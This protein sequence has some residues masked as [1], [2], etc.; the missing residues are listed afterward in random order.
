MI[1]TFFKRLFGGG[2][3]KPKQAEPKPPVLYEG[4]EIIAEP[5][6]TN[7]QWQVAGRIEKEIG[8]TRKVHIF[9][10]ADTLPDEEEAVT[11]TLRKAK[12]LIDQQGDRI[13]D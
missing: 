8:D 11:H 3:A 9:I 6:L 4:Y 12:L 13:F 1:G 5:Q 7:G 2:S 10:R